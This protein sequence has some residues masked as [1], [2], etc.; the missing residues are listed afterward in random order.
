MAVFIFD[1]TK[2][3]IRSIYRLSCGHQLL[4]LKEIV[5]EN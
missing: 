1:K 5:L 3:I 4:L 2:K